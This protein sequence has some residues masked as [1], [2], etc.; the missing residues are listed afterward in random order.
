MM[1]LRIH[2]LPL[3]GLE[4]SAH[5]VV[6]ERAGQ[7]FIREG[8]ADR[9]YQEDGSLLPRTEPNAVISSQEEIKKQVLRIAPNVDS[10]CLHGDTP[11][12]VTFAESIYRALVDAGFEVGAP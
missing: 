1:I 6:A 7:S 11:D 5:R 3:M 12:C 2:R 10:I 8:F 9:T 4:G